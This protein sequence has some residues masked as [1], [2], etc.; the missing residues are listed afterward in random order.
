MAH[1]CV[2]SA[3]Q[4]AIGMGSGHVSSAGLRTRQRGIRRTIERARG[5]GGTF[6]RGCNRAHGRRAM[7][8]QGEGPNHRGFASDFG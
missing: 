1:L 8:A 5:A 4:W 3:R 2:R 6:D 7:P